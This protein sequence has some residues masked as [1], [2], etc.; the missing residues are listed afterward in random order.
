MP[1]ADYLVRA[2]NSSRAFGVTV[3]GSTTA[4]PGERA[5][6]RLPIFGVTLRAVSMDGK[7]LQ[8]ASVRLH[9]VNMAADSSGRATFP[10]VPAGS[11]EV[12]ISYGGATVYREKIEVKDNVYRDLE[13]A[14][15]DVSA[16]FVSADGE[17]MV[18]LW[19]LGARDRG[20]SGTGDRIS[21]EMLPE[22]EYRLTAT[23]RRDGREVRLLEQAVR[24]SELRGAVI[25]LPIGRLALRIV[26]DDGTPFEGQATVAG[27]TKRI[28]NGRVEFELL[29][30]GAYNITVR[31]VGDI[32]VLR[33]GVTH[34][35]AEETIRISSSSIVVR[36][37]DM[38]GRPIEGAG[39]R[40]QSQKIPGVLAT[41]TTG[42]DGEARFTKIPT[43]LAPFIV[44]ATY[45]GRTEEKLTGPG[46]ASITIP[47]IAIGGT[48][49]DAVIV[50]ATIGLIA[51]VIAV[52]ATARVL[53]RRR[54]A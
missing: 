41:A 6:I 8:G 23:I 52:L 28:V 7:P 45:G 22:G 34:G 17:P 4:R 39:V 18:V 25:R 53:S 47:A 1:I 31:G 46:E 15:Y 38:L 9:S 30:F 54:K 49:I 51:A 43:A 36:V 16:S 37:S 2:T 29:P 44:T 20:L 33:T 26:W 3:E 24:P 32:E 5:E 12:E 42:P 40:I 27:E 35:G 10:G 19:S 21:I 11:Y 14:V 50:F 13:C 48:L